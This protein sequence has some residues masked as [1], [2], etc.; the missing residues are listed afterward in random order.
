MAEDTP[1]I[2]Q[3]VTNIHKNKKFTKPELYRALSNLIEQ[4]AHEGSG[5]FRD[6]FYVVRESNG[7]LNLLTASDDNIVQPI[8]DEAII[9]SIL[10]FCHF[11]T[12]KKSDFQNFDYR[13]AKNAFAMWKA[14]AT[15]IERPRSV[16]FKGDNELCYHRL[17]YDPVSFSY[18]ELMPWID[19]L[20]SS[21]ENRSCRGLPYADRMPRSCE[22]F[23]RVSNTLALVAYGG[24][25]FFDEANTEQYLFML[26][27][28]G[29]GKGSLCRWFEM[30]FGP[31]YGTKTLPDKDFNFDNT[32]ATP[33]LDMRVITIPEM[34]NTKLVTSNI[35]KSIIGSDLIE[36]RNL[37]GRPFPAKLKV[38]FFLSSNSELS[39]SS[40]K[41][42][43]RRALYCEF[44]ERVG[45]DDPMYEK[46]LWDETPYLFG[47]MLAVYKH[48]C[49]NHGKIIVNNDV[50][51][52]VI[53]VNEAELQEIFDHHFE[54][55]PEASFSSQ[56]I[57]K[58][59]DELHMKPAFYA[60]F[61]AFMKSRHKIKPYRP[62][63]SN[64]PNRPVFYKGARFKEGTLSQV[65]PLSVTSQDD[66]FTVF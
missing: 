15:P 37:F 18:D 52:N 60:R 45:E 39:I 25:A 23:Y 50:L 8:V 55:D 44:A 12:E 31:A 1:G 42:D 36:V 6:R 63:D 26:G 28:G 62:R 3:N 11:H 35:F 24:S 2:K 19:F 57:L 58:V 34:K 21:D 43:V 32:W 49:P 53:A 41:S 20:S 40:Q 38:K 46:K 48:V 16:R 66:S 61:R 30:M 4:K 14:L 47:L 56:I 9:G 51:D 13:D 22:L 10:R 59:R 7:V 54:V 33:F 64:N 65:M 17:V 5:G 27:D 29:N